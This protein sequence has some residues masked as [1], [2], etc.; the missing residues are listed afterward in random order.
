MNP[1]SV[2]MKDK[3]VAAGVG[4][5]GDNAGGWSIYIGVEPTRPRQAITL[6]DTGGAHPNYTMNNAL[7][8]Q[9]GETFQVRVRAGDYLT[10]YNKI[11]ECVKALAQ[12]GTFV[13]GTM[14]YFNVFQD[15]D[16][17]FLGKNESDE[18]IWTANFKVVREER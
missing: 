3:L 15:S 1:V 11:E 9:R 12:I 18:Y 2:D 14:N 7:E 17:F 13:V 16:I 5:S 10:G 4:V 8:P 6:Y